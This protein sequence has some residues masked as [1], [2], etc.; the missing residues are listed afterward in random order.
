MPTHTDTLARIYA[1]SLFEVSEESGGRDG[2]MDVANELEEV[3]ELVRADASFREFLSSPLI[4]SAA[5]RDSLKAIFSGRV[6]EIVFNF[7]MVLNAHDRLGHLEM[8]GVAMMQMVHEH[9]GR[10]EVDVTTAKALD[11][12]GRAAVVTELKKIIGKDPVIHSYVNPDLIGGATFRIGDQLI[13][14]SVATQLKRLEQDLQKAGSHGIRV[15]PERYI[16]GGV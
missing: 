6:S 7:L 1:R 14:G 9:W 15:H 2:V 5:R 12:A 11:D 3:C 10:V 4:E 13:D 8:I 16:E